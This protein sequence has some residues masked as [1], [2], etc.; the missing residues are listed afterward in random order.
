M[1]DDWLAVWDL[2][3]ETCRSHILATLIE[4]ATKRARADR[5]LYSSNTVN[6]PTVEIYDCWGS[7]AHLTVS[8]LFSWW[9]WCPAQSGSDWN[10]HYVYRGTA[11][12]EGE[13]LA[14]SEAVPLRKNYVSE[15]DEKDYDLEAVL[16]AVRAELRSTA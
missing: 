14:S 6:D 11:T 13:V 3:E 4:V 8:Y 16:R 9:E 15:Y 5:D 1:S 7:G 10:Y 12:F 2:L